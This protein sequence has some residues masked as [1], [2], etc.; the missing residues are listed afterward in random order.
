MQGK[1]FLLRCRSSP[2]HL[3]R[4]GASKKEVSEGSTTSAS[5]TKYSMCVTGRSPLTARRDPANADYQIRLLV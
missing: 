2:R 5:C 1:K 4:H 3:L